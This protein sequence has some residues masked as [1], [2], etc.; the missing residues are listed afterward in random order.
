MISRERKTRPAIVSGSFAEDIPATLGGRINVVEMSGF[1]SSPI[2][3]QRGSFFCS[4]CRVREYVLFCR[5]T[6]R[7]MLLIVSDAFAVMGCRSLASLRATL[8]RE[9]EIERN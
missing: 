7:H 1:H 8:A 3:N 9:T 2:G 5:M 4:F 6:A